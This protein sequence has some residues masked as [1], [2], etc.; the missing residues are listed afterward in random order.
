MD[1]FKNQVFSISHNP[2]GDG[3]CQFTVLS[4]LLQ[5]IGIHRFARSVCEE[6]VN[7]LSETPE[8]SEGQP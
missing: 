1:S 4:Y 2:S 7:Y 5:K 8:N 6:V 3:N